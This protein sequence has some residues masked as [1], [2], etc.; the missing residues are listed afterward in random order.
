LW[1]FDQAVTS[2]DDFL[3]LFRKILSCIESNYQ[4]NLIFLQKYQ[5]YLKRFILY[6]YILGW[7]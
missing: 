2:Q 7:F 3:P 4:Y 6:G 1:Q 5:N